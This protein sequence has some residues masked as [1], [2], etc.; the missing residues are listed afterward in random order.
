VARASRGRRIGSRQSTKRKLHWEGSH[1]WGN[2]DFDLS[3]HP[4]GTWWARYPSG[5][6]DSPEG[7][8]WPNASDETLI[9]TIVDSKVFWYATE[10]P[11]VRMT[12]FTIGLIAW[13]AAQAFEYIYDGALFDDTSIVGVPPH[14]FFDSDADWII[15]QTHIFPGQGQYSGPV[16]RIFL[17]SRSMR[18]LPPTTGVLMVAAPHGLAVEDRNVHYEWAIDCRQLFKSGY[19]R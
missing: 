11:P 1:F 17:E 15:R 10:L 14:P 12:Q 4:L 2:I 7:E 16:D 3:V 8:T 13:D 19:T 5:G 18:K 6:I 9:R